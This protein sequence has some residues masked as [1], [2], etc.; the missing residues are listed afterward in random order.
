MDPFDPGPTA[1]REDTMLKTARVAAGVPASDL[2]RAKAWYSEKLGLEPDPE[3]DNEGGSVYRCADGTAF[4]VYQSAGKSDASFTQLM[5]DVADIDA[6]VGELRG[7]GV[8]LMDYDTPFVKTTDG[9]AEM[10]IGRGC[11]IKDSEGN[12]IA[13]TQQAP[14][15]ALRG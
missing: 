2:A 8:T 4:I 7:K 14:V 6:E 15:P 5:F 12:L 11:W 13:I 10:P 9:I 1:E 3:M